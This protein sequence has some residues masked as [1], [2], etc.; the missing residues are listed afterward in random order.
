MEQYDRGVIGRR[1]L[2]AGVLALAAPALAPGSEAAAADMPKAIKPGQ[3]IN[4]VH[5]YVSDLDK[6]IKFYKDL[7]GAEVWDTTPGNATMHLPNKP[8][9]ISLTVTKD[10]PYI[11]HVAYGVDFDQKG[12]DAKKVADAI[13]QAYPTAKAKPTGPSPYGE[14]TRS[15]YLYDPDGI[16]LQLVPKDDDGWL[17]GG[18]KGKAILKK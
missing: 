11:N 5:L 10:K 7:V 8:C 13:N 1:A 4:H 18:P 16:Y 6:E 3:L 12:G 9:W 14:N 17:P 2:L 15:V